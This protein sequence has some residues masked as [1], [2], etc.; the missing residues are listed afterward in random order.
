[1]RIRRVSWRLFPP[2]KETPARRR[3]TAKGSPA[4]GALFGSGLVNAAYRA[5]GELD[6]ERRGLGPRELLVGLER[7]GH[8]FRAAH[9]YLALHSAITG[10]VDRFERTRRGRYRWI[11]APD[12]RAPED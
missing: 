9:P 4:A 8:T 6:P 2:V 11:P 3:G 10:A 7:R 1:M 12:D 5:A